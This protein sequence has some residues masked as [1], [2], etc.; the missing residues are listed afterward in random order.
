LKSFKSPRV[1]Y[2]L[3]AERR[4][5]RFKA[6]ASDLKADFKLALLPTTVRGLTTFAAGFCYTTA[7]LHPFSSYFIQDS[8]S[9]IKK[10]VA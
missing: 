1:Q 10:E 7:P 9:F 4:R 8:E 6:P 5:K 2:G 3:Y